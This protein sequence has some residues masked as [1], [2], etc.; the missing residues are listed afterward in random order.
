[1]DNVLVL[2]AGSSSLKF[3][4]FEKAED[5]VIR[6]SGKVERIGGDARFDL[7]DA[8]GA[9]LAEGPLEAASG[10]THAGALDAVLREVDDRFGTARITAVGHRVVHG[11]LDYTAPVELTPEVL[12]RLEGF[13]PFAPLHQPHNL[14]GIRAATDAFPE[15]KQV[16][17]FDTAFHRGHPFVNDTFA[18]PRRFYDQGVRRYGFHGLS[19]DY[20]SGRLEQIDPEA[21][22]GRVIVAHLGNGASMCGMQAGRSVASSMG[23]T[24]LDGLPMGTRSGQIDPGVLLYLLEQEGMSLSEVTGMLYKQ[25][26]LL[27][28]SGISHDM[29]TLLASDAPEARQA[30][31]YFTFRIR[32]E[33]GGLAAALNGLDALVFTGGIG[34]NAAQIRAEVCDG[35]G[36]IGIALDD[37][38]NREGELRIDDGDGSVKVFVIP[39]NEELVIARAAARA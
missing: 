21:H 15:A 19:Y 13:T 7:K 38:A 17:C 36:W 6:A 8:G 12:E 29:R 31:D 16:A 2:N 24:A 9:L 33:L 11:G 30:I 20:I 25:S 14:A 22:A 28:L 26:G 5:P 10:Q 23:F 37:A 27:G 4:L 18:I 32:R 35:L 39:T 34:E 3:G 1:M